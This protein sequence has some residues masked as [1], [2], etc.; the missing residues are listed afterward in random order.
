MDFKGF[1]KRLS[2]K[3]VAVFVDAPNI[4]RPEFSI[5]LSSVTKEAREAGKVTLARLYMKDGGELVTVAKKLGFEPVVIKEGD[6]KVALTIDA[7]ETA[8]KNLADIFLI[9]TRN[10]AYLPLI[11][12]LKMMG[13]K[14]IIFG[15]EPG[16]SIAIQRASDK[17]FHYDPAYGL[18]QEELRRR[19]IMWV[20]GMLLIKVDIIAI[21]VLFM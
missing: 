18:T 2:K 20:V 16:F 15:T 9:A 14:V 19:E 8:A 3:R 13:K 10:S 4:L 21:F 1:F 5:D 12:H 6:V 11:Y 17:V 7:I